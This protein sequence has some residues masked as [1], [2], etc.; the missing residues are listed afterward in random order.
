MSVQSVR[1]ALRNELERL[2]RMDNEPRK[3]AKEAQRILETLAHFNVEVGE[4]RRASLR[5]LRNDYGYS[6]GMLA[7]EFEITKARAQQIVG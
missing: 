6:W 4:V 7:E 3:Q 2:K 5:S 1:T